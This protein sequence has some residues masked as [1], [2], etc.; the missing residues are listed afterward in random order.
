MNLLNP[1]QF[2]SRH[3][4]EGTAELLQSVINWFEARG[5]TRLKKDWHD[6]VWNY[7][8]VAFMKEQQVLATLMTPSGYGDDAHWDSLR[9]VQFAE[10]SAF[11]GIAYWYTFQVS[12]LGLGPVFNGDNEA[13][14]QRAARLLR[15]GGVFAFGLSE[16]EHGADIYSSDMEL[17]PQADGTYLAR[18]DKYYIGNGNEA[19]LVSVFAKNAETGEYVFFIV[20][21]KHPNYTCV[22]NTVAHQCYVSEFTLNDYPITED[23]ILSSGQKA[24][25]DMLNTINYC[26][27]NLGFGSI[28]L[29][30]H[31]LY[32][33]M[34]HAANRNLYG[35]YV[36]DFPQVKRLFTDSYCRLIAMKLFAYRATDYMRCASADDRRYLL[37]NPLV[38]M[39]VT[40]QGEQVVADLFDVIAARGFEQEPFFEVAAREIGMLPKLEGTAHVNMGLVVKFMRNYMF[41]PAEFEPVP[42]RDEL[43]DDTFLFHQGPTR[44]LGDVRFH[45]YHIAYGL[46]DLP[47]IQV[48]KGQIASFR[49]M[50]AE[51]GPDEQQ[52]K[53]IDYML[54][55]GEL[56]TLV[57]YGQLILEHA[58]MDDTDSDLL[59]QIFDVFVRDF[60]TYAA[61]LHGKPANTDQQRQFLL[62]LIQAPAANPEQFDTVWREQVYA[63]KG[64]YQLRP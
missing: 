23:D 38:K 41:N 24:W 27:F 43:A 45:D 22:K 55:L 31:A 30:S 47:N 48:F 60:S 20:D 57:V 17:I 50:L 10:I 7:D 49:T 12:M 46:F 59:N 1:H 56:F 39:K 25:D 58:A 9:N 6:K 13:A 33:A 15:E 40:M 28:G 26:K 52:V 44:G 36:T 3:T 32:E 11:Y 14:K 35:R 37:Y 19:A 2:Q 51:A 64:Q 4:D 8:F 42:Q 61:E 63:L 54:G 18:G 16:K 29:A 53:D 5:L 21:S 34:D 62:E